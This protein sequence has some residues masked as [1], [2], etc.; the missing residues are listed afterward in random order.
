[1]LGGATFACIQC[2]WT[3]RRGCFNFHTGA[4][5]L[6]PCGIAGD[7]DCLRVIWI[8]GDLDSLRC[9]RTSRHCCMILQLAPLVAA[10]VGEQRERA[11]G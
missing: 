10:A 6:L 5:W 2:E 7:L 3:V 11:C 4:V 1:M 8:A 9:A